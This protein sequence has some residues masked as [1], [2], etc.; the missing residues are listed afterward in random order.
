[1]NTETIVKKNLDLHAEWMRYLFEHPEAMDQLPDGAQ[2]IIL[3]TD[4]TELARE[5]TKLLTAAKAEG[6]PIVVVHLASPKPPIPQI[7]VLSAR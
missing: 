5:N 7:E 6:V 4:D 3:P 2:V 1:M